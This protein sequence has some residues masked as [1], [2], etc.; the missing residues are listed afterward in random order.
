MTVPAKHFET[1]R[2]H[3]H[4]ES[5]EASRDAIING[6]STVAQEIVA[7]RARIEALNAELAAF[8]IIAST[9]TELADPNLPLAGISV[10]VKDLYDTV[11]MVT[12]YGSPIYRNHMPAADAALVTRLRNLGAF[13]AG[14]TVTTEFAWRQ[15]GAT[16]NPWNPA[17]TPGGSSSGSAAAVAAGIVPVALGTQ[18]FGSIIRP[19]AFCGVVGFK[20]TYGILP[21]EG[22]CP[23]SPTLDHAGLLARSVADISYL[24][25]LLS[26]QHLPTAKPGHPPRLRMVRG[27]FWDQASSQQR[28][29]LETAA[30]QFAHMGAS[31]TEREL[32]SEFEE[33]FASAETILIKEAAGLYG[34]LIERSPELVSVHIKDLAKR[35]LSL[36]EGEY[37]KALAFRDELQA[38]FKHEVEGYDAILTLPALGE[39]PLLAEGTGNAG[40]CV[41]W[42]LLGAPAIALP[43]T[44]GAGNLPLGLQLVGSSGGDAS[45]LATA[46]WCE[47]ANQAEI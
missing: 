2:I 15:A 27:P 34:P 44:T 35:G 6:R 1:P 21:L 25:G 40:P 17:H 47:A 14:K 31:I 42:T 19:A 9:P 13:I 3:V 5:I 46:A 12:S 28:E 37:E 24:F 10:G 39:A 22:V 41:V 33:G 4:G 36:R 20:P 11:D 8:E 38:A 16:V 7:C 45:L 32:P 26:G 23:L 29:T 43:R 30:I 18:T